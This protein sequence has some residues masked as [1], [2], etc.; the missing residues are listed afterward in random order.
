MLVGRGSFRK[1]LVNLCPKTEFYTEKIQ[2]SHTGPEITRKKKK[3]ICYHLCFAIDC[4]V[5]FYLAVCNISICV[6]LLF[7][8]VCVDIVLVTLYMKNIYCP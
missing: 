8:S 7:A 3:G 6:N 5:I 2:V 1:S 4:F